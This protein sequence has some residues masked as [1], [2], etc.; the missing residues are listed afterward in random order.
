[1]SSGLYGVVGHEIGYTLSPLIFCAAFESLGWRADYSVI[2][3]DKVELPGL[4]STMRHAP[5]RGLSVTKPYKE[6]VV[7]FLDRLD[8]SAKAIGA[9]NTIVKSGRRLVGYNTDV[10]GVEAALKRYRDKLRNRDAV[11]FGAGGAARAVAYTL[12]SR[13]GMR[14]VTIAARRPAQ[15][16]RLIHDLQDRLTPPALA[17]GAFRPVGE[18]DDALENAVLVVNATPIGAG[19]RGTIGLFPHGTRIRSGVIAFD[20]VYRPRP[21]G[22]TVAAR[23]AGCRTVIDGWP[24]LIAQAEKAFWLWTGRKFPREVSRKLQNLKTLP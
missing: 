6:A 20:L 1:V 2:D 10:D 7:P 15:A 17:S 19:R 12:L 16:R 13:L 11:I 22:F 5:I 24:M 14:S 21:T 23:R 18:L 3:I 4:I 8:Q 9:V